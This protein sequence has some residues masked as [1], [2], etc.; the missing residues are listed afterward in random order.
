[1]MQKNQQRF[2]KIPKDLSIDY[3]DNKSLSYFD[4]I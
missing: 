2:C 1:M 3:V 4:T